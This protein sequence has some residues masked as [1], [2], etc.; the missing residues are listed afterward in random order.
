MP[1][2]HGTMTFCVCTLPQP[3]PKDALARFAAKAAGPLERVEHEPQL[4]WVTGRHLLENRIDEKTA[5]A[6]GYLHLSLRQAVRKIPASLLRAECRMAE[7]ALLAD[8][9]PG[10]T[11][12]RNERR[13]IKEEVTER[14]LPTMPP[15]LTGLPFVV[16]EN[17]KRVYVGASS[18]RQ[19]DTF[20]AMFSQTVGFDLVPQTPEALAVMH[21][22]KAAHDLVPF[23]LSPAL[24]DNKATG[25]LGQ[26]FLT[27][28]WF[29]LD[30]RK[31]VL[32]KT[33]L[34]EFSMQLDGPL[35]FV[36][37]GEGAFESAIRKGLPT[38]SAEAKAAL[39][40]GKKLRRAKITLARGDSDQ[41]TTGIDADNF[42][43]RGLKVPDGETLEPNA[44]F[45]E[46]VINLYVFHTVL[47]ELFK[48]FVKELSDPAR[49]A[50]IQ[51]D[52]KAW[53]Q[54]LEGK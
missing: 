16:D 6:G 53:V 8:K 19:L 49:R 47:T 50:A 37:E 54:A 33:Q 12:A 11:V 35:V 38:Q 39:L 29:Y 30:G 32:P 20:N 3:M 15:Q 10:D 21:I 40:V 2:D 34:G 25:T 23:N 41:W 43:F 28:L 24:A 4:G 45:E 22:G 52:A 46:R 51:R 44:V 27:W 36:A 26:N 42:S 5:F 31:G 14:L 7:L 17:Y 18:E 48:H 13:Q 9:K 1:F